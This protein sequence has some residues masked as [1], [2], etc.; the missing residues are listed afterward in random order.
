VVRS[1]RP[2]RTH[3]VPAAL[4]PLLV[5]SVA[6]LF[7]AGCGATPDAGDA[8]AVT[9]SAG[10]EIV[11][12]LRRPDTMTVEGPPAVRIGDVDGANVWDVGAPDGRQLVAIRSPGASGSYASR[13]IEPTGSR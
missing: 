1:R 7:L 2:H 3:R 5:T 6:P 11:R 4:V 10:I 13:P 8:I 12:N 9:D